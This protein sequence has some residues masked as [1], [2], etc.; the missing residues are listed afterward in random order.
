MTD[1]CIILGAGGHARVLIEC[2]RASGVAQI[3]GIL[4]PDRERWGQTLFDVP[5]LGGD[6]L[7]AQMVA[8]GVQYFVVGLGSTGN[9]EARQRL[10]Q[11]GQS[12]GLQPLTVIHPACIHSPSA[13][14][15][16]G[17][18]LLAGSIVN[19]G[20]LIGK[21][22]IVN[23]GAIV[24]HDCQIED[25]AHIATGA[26]LAGSVHVGLGAH[27]GIGAVVR[28]GITIGEAA[29]VGAGAAVVEDVPP[30]TVVVG[31]PAKVLRPVQKIGEL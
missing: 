21:N 2:V 18:Q 26:M 12:Q 5:I 11:M 30:G 8:E 16:A 28:Q 27:I 29:V 25:H 19:A 7:M 14:I 4:D 3:H 31:V 23:S 17:S 10:F 9:S 20:A 15:G 24:E 13:V 1:R 22:V 6:E